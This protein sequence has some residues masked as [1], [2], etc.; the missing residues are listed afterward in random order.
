LWSDFVKLLLLRHIQLAEYD[1]SFGRPDGIEGPESRSSLLANTGVD[2]TKP[3]S[4]R[5]YQS[6]EHVWRAFDSM[7]MFGRMYIDKRLEVR[8]G[9]CSGLNILVLDHGVDM[10]Y[11]ESR[12]RG[13]VY[14]DGIQ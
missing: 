11:K 13:R 2:I 14:N 4:G 6:V 1:I 8:G 5:L 7:A 12:R 10:T 9:I 3:F